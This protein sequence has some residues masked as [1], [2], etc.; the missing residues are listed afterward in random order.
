MFDT[1]LLLKEELDAIVEKLQERA[2]KLGEIQADIFKRSEKL[3]DAIELLDP[4]LDEKAITLIGRQQ[5][6]DEEDV[7]KYFDPANMLDV[8]DDFHRIDFPPVE[9]P[10][11]WRLEPYP[12][13]DG[14]TSPLQTL[15]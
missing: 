8:I 5:F 1:L 3:T 6:G 10:Q 11:R 12:W 2:D 7:A 13:P 4:E 9:D 14:S 15:P